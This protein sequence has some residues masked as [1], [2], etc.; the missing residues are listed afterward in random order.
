MSKICSLPLSELPRITSLYTEEREP[1]DQE[2]FI[3]PNYQRGYRW[4]AD[5]HVEALLEDV[6]AFM[7][8]SRRSEERY[9]LQ[10]I[11]VSPSPFKNGAWEVIDGQQRLTTLYLI[12]KAFN[13][14]TFRLEFET[15]TQSDK[16]L[17][18]LVEK[19]LFDD[20]QPD[21]YFMSNAWKKINSWISD[22]ERK[23]NGFKR[24]FIATLLDEVHVIWYD[25]ESSDRKNNISVFER[26]NV[27]K[28]PLTDAELVKALLLS[29]LKGI[30]TDKELTM[31]QSEISNEWHRMETELQKPQKWGFLTANISEELESHLDLL[32]NLIA[33]EKNSTNYST[34]L[35]FEKQILTAGDTPDKQGE[36][37]LSLWNDIKQAFACVN[38]WFC[39]ATPETKPT[40][41]H[42]VGYLLATKEKNIGEIYKESINRS[43]SSFVKKLREWIHHCI[44]DLNLD[45]INYDDNRKEIEKLLLLFNVLSCEAIAEGMYNRFPF[46]R[47]NTI[48]LERKGSGGWSVEHIAAQQSQDPLKSPKA[49]KSWAS[50]TLRAIE[51][52]HEVSHTVVEID[53]ETSKKRTFEKSENLDQIKAELRSIEHTPDNSINRESFNTLHNK[54]VNIFAAPSI[55]DLSNLALLS[56]KDNSTLNNAIFPVKRD[57]IIQLEREGRFIPPCTRNVFLKFYSEADTQPFYWGRED[58]ERYLEAI[59]SVINKFKSE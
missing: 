52:I 30:Y 33:G 26:L 14:S 36:K 42:Y 22:H 34:Y 47:Y 37:A 27:G 46:D 39:D 2:T 29:K 3:I 50:E 55:H 54:V 12:L 17:Q 24:K 45:E 58:Q 9:C 8:T 44:V 1:V 5:L 18:D 19:N 57:R 7:N 40:I 25:L 49:I 4:E 23:R 20:S 6:N 11:V 10:P 31:R 28:I 38:S 13:D 32:F 21:F 16:F 56:A 59:K 53:M 51:H 41:Y 48:A 35:W 43:K 15:R